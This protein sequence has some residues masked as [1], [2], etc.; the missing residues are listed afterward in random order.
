M[1]QPNA[2]EAKSDRPDA[3]A[4]APPG[5]PTPTGSPSPTSAG[6]VTFR[7]DGREVTAAPGTNL[8]D[9]AKTVGV[10][11]PYYCYHPRLSVV[12]NCR[13]CMVETS[14][15]AKL[16]P[17]CQTPVTQ[18]IEVRTTTDRVRAQQKMVMEFLLLNHPVD[19]SICDQAGECKLQDYY[20]RHDGKPS[21]LRGPKILRNKRKPLSDNIVLDQERCILC[22]RC[23]RFMEEVAKAPQLGVFGRGSHEVVD[24]APH[25][26]KLESNYSG[27]I[28]DLCPVGALLDRDFRFRAR[29][30][31]LSATP[32]LCTGCSRGCSIWADTMGQDAFRFRPRENEAVNK[33]WMCDA[34]RRTYRQI[35]KH[36]LLRCSVG[37]GD[38]ARDA[39]PSEAVH[40]AV[41]LLQGAAGDVALLVSPGLSNEDLLATAALARD[42]LDVDHVYETGRP[43]GA[44]DSFLMTADK[45][46][47]RRGLDAIAR[48]FGLTLRPAS[49]LAARFGGAPPKAVV[50]FGGDLPLESPEL[51]AALGRTGLVVL[52]SNESPLTTAAAIVFA[53]SS[54]LEDEG[55]FV[56]GDG[57][58]Q[59]ARQAFP[60]KEG[61]LAT[62]RWCEALR[63]ALTTAKPPSP[64]AQAAAPAPTTDF[65]AALRPPASAGELFARYAPRVP[66]L[67]AFDWHGSAPVHRP[68]PG[69]K[70]LAAAADG[71][72]AGWREGGIPSTR[73]LSLPL[74]T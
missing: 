21:R 18:G 7:V 31:F 28:V 58:I 55:S 42:V 41:A 34:G 44:A 1:S 37:R 51:L 74:E 47:N 6:L 66:E 67:A 38:Q 59:R 24:V 39:S 23:V 8:I 20:A 4:P 9:A 19:C 73:G 48:G 60:P 56:Q 15:A 71:R 33:S 2:P 68:G 46:A 12:A 26:G 72:P 50:A 27:N 10:E 69:R 16:V 36:R 25:L 5:A 22:T 43:A 3:A 11:I 65:G 17:A 40:E 63:A 52:A 14:A 53:A 32:T 70:T 30:W 54:H 45:N 57:L 62:W 35:G 64:G 29:A 61:A 49:E 13:M